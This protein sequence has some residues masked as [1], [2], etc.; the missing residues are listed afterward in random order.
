MIYIILGEAASVASTISTSLESIK[1]DVLEVIST[2]APIGI[3]IM[4]TFLVWRYGI[5]FFKS[6][7]K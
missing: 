7:S 5:K 2:V 3:A 4:G 1:G 6:V